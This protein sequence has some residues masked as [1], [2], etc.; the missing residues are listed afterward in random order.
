[1]DSIGVLAASEPPFV[2]TVLTHGLGFG[3]IMAVSLWA[4]DAFE[5][6]VPPWPRWALVQALGAV[7]GDIL[8]GG[9]VCWLDRQSARRP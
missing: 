8:Y 9:I 6:D 2:R 7:L 1:M 3:L 4:R 5:G